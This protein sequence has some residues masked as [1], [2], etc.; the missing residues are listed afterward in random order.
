MAGIGT[1][2]VGD[3]R[4]PTVS[5]PGPIA[6]AGRILEALRQPAR[7]V[8]VQR[9]GEHLVTSIAPEPVEWAGVLA[10]HN[11]ED[12]IAAAIGADDGRMLECVNDCHEL[13]LCN[14]RARRPRH[15]IFVPPRAPLAT[16]A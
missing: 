12:S 6:P 15:H 13:Q 11:K 5:V 7:V 4:L 1:P 16:K 10:V 2:E 9:S 3:D 14:P 8:P